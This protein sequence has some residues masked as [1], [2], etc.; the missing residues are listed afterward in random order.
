MGKVPEPNLV[1][2]GVDRTERLTY[3]PVCGAEKVDHTFDDLIPCHAP[4]YG[5]RVRAC[6]K[7]RSSTRGGCAD[8]VRR[9]ALDPAA[10]SDGGR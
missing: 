8:L 5:E 4:R 7:P 1:P 10:C 9:A 6:S 2:R 3:N